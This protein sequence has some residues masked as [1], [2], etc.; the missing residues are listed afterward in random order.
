M[1]EDEEE[2]ANHKVDF[3]L[4][5]QCHRNVRARVYVSIGLC[6]RR[7]TLGRKIRH[8]ADSTITYLRLPSQSADAI[9]HQIKRDIERKRWIKRE[10]KRQK[11]NT[12]RIEDRARYRSLG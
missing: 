4:G 6:V 1:D 2:E 5:I 11:W 10:R 12:T 7:L 9:H 8:T 3:F